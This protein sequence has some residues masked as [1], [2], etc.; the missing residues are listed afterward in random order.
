[1]QRPIRTVLMLAGS[2]VALC[3]V[4]SIGFVAGATALGPG[5]PPPQVVAGDPPPEIKDQT[6]E[7]E[8]DFGLFWEAWTVIQDNYFDGP[9]AAED[10]REG[11]IR[12]LAQ[13]TEDPYTL[14]QDPEQAQ[15]SS[16]HLSGS[17]VGVGIRI[18]LRDDFPFV[19]QPLPQSPAEA[20]G[21]GI[22]EYVVAVDGVSTEG[23]ALADF[24]ASCAASAGHR[25][26]SPCG[27]KAKRPSATS[28]SSANASSSNR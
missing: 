21:I 27:A 19:I 8:V 15:R 5:V 22:H 12:G 13:A 20:A 7:E 2:V 25:S 10:L 24:D 16:A 4:F 17:Y 3:F 28:R 6:E 9:L 11:A 23:M 26:P 14:Y 1:M 18:E